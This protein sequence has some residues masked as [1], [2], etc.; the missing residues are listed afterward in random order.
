MVSAREV[1]P[2]PRG[3]ANR[4]TPI[5]RRECVVKAE[6][7]GRQSWTYKP[8]PA[9]VSGWCIGLGNTERESS[10]AGGGFCVIRM[11]HILP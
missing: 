3:A 1:T 4:G 10:L 6:S 2:I 8:K 7:P 9:S 5:L 11:R